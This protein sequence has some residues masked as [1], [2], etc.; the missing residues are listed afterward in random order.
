MKRKHRRIRSRLFTATLPCLLLLSFAAGCGGEPERNSVMPVRATIG[1]GAVTGLYY[2]AGGAMAS[3]V[4]RNRDVHGLRLNV[5]S[6]PGSVY[7]IN[8]VLAG[9]LEFGLAQSDRQCQAWH[10]LVEWS[11]KGPQK[12]LRSV[13]CLHSE[14]LTLVASEES[15]IR[16]VSDLAGKSVNIGNPGSGHRQNAIDALEAAGIDYAGQMVSFGYQQQQAV[17]LFLDGVID[18]FFYTVGHPAQTI[19]NAVNGP[20]QARFIPIESIQARDDPCAMYVPTSIPADFY[21]RAANGEDIPTFGLQATLI[22]SAR[23]PESIVYT[24][25]REVY[26]N[27]GELADLHPGLGRITRGCMVGAQ[28]A[29]LHEG[30][31]RYIRESGMESS[32]GSDE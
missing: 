32:A 10:G 20:I 11:G 18:A 26:E 27:A 28:T 15:G 14:A 2:P 17:D 4:S 1:T 8:A 31:A 3:I 12:N 30:A 23:V 19:E 13:L 22:T 16:S 6:T 7:N 24:F 9:D 29:P 25:C 5:E 21:P